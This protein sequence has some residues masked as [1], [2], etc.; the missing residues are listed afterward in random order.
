MKMGGVERVVKA[1]KKEEH[2]M[3][4]HFELIH[5]I[6]VREA[7]LPGAS[8][9]D[10]IEYIDVDGVLLFD[11][12]FSWK[13]EKVDEVKKIVRDQWGALIQFTSEALGLQ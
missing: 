13:Y 6:I 4:P 2:D 9:E 7:I 5:D 3:V 8:Y 1:L 12:V 10:F 11:K